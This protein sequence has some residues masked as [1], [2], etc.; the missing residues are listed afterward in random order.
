MER[1]FTS[2]EQEQMY[3]KLRHSAWE[4]KTVLRK[5]PETPTQGEYVLIKTEPA[6]DTFGVTINHAPEDDFNTAKLLQEPPQIVKRSKKPK[7]TWIIRDIRESEYKGQFSIDYE[8][9]QGS[10]LNV[11]YSPIVNNTSLMPYTSR[12]LPVLLET[13]KAGNTN[14]NIRPTRNKSRSQQEIMEEM[15]QLLS[16]ILSDESIA[17]NFETEWSMLRSDYENIT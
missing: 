8:N 3:E 14:I 17:A 4:P 11:N 13:L 15:Y 16:V 10:V 7:A 1:K 6:D 5:P 2:L 9:D 12:V